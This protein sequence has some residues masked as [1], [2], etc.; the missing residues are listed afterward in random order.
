[1]LD[2]ASG[3]HQIPIAEKDKKKTVFSIPY[4]HYGFNRMPFGL[5]NAPATFQRLMNTILA[6]I[7]GIR[8][9]VYLD[10]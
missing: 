6:G 8:C 1:M 3:Y 9:L 2:L 10:I 5:K 4:G 7:Q